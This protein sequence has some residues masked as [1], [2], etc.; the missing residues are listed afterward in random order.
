MTRGFNPGSFKVSRDSYVVLALAAGVLIAGYFIVKKLVGDAADAAGGVLSGNNA[1]TAGTPYAGAGIAGTLGAGT[2]SVLGGAPQAIG[3]SIG[4]GLFSL[5]GA[6]PQGSD[7]FY[8]VTFPDGSVHAVGNAAIDAAS[9]FT[10]GG[11]RYKLG[12]DGY[13]NKVA[14]AVTTVYGSGASGGASGS[15]FESYGPY[16]GGA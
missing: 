8:R 3:E 9:T 11:V 4:S 10:F 16:M 13:G 2:N 15:L 6:S 5:F 1:L 14:T 12:D 7:T